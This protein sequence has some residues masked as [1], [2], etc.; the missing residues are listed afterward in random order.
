M[1]GPA[2]ATGLAAAMT[3]SVETRARMFPNIMYDVCGGDVCIDLLDVVEGARC[4]TNA[5]SN[6]RVIV[7]LCIQLHAKQGK[8][9]EQSQRPSL[10]PRTSRSVGLS[11]AS[12]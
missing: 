8:E 12:S 11:T 5:S 3:A 1:I 10:K 6:D 7:Q 4:R 9:T 2:S